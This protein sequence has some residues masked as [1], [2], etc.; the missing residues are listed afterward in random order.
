MD[1]LHPDPVEKR[2][3]DLGE[4]VHGVIPNVKGMGARDALLML[5]SAGCT[6]VEI[7][8]TGKV[9]SQSG[10]MGHTVLTLK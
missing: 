9:V 2:S 10:N 3:A 5:E 1:S 4:V 6:N 7:H 8:G